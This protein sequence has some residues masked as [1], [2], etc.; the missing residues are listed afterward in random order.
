MLELHH[1]TLNAM[2]LKSNVKLENL[3][4]IDMYLFF[5]KGIRGGQSV[6]F[7][8]HSKAN[9]KYLND[10]N[11]NEESKHII[12]LDANNLYG[13]A[14][15]HK[16]P[17]SGFKWLPV[18]QMTYD[19]IMSYVDNDIGYVLEV[20]L[21][22]PEHLHDKHNDYP[23]APER[24]KVGKD[25]KLCGTF[26]DKKNYVVHIKNLKFYLEQGLELT[27]INRV[28][29]FKQS[30]WLEDWINLNTTFRTNAT[31]EF[32]K[33]YFKLM[34]NAVFGK[35]MENVRDRVDIKCAFN[36]D[37]FLKYTTK[38]NFKR[39]CKFGDDVNYFMVMEMEKKTVELNKPIY[40]GFSILDFSKLHMYKFHYE[41]MKNKYQDKIK[42]LMTDTDSLVYEV[43]TDDI[44]EDMNAM[45]DYFDMSEYPKDSKYHNGKNKK[46]IG[47]FKDEVSN[48]YISEFIGIR[49]KTYS[50]IKNNDEI[51]KK[52][53][54][55]S[56][57]VVKKEITFDDYKLCIFENKQKI[58][59]IHS[60]RSKD[61]SNYS[62]VQS[63]IAL[64][65]SDD[66]RCWIDA[67]NSLAWGHRR[68]I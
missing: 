24:F 19:K 47:K 16:L 49:S 48:D 34:N 64:N 21:K 10:Y 5:E 30:N 8:K 65:N 59:Q 31:N 43:Q 32:E 33:D 22:Y 37:Y 6:I 27:K 13:E 4:D 68:I 45:S 18:E 60:I 25:E 14:M 46:V 17:I 40:A 2:L 35:T 15:S 54:G 44:Y 66:K 29:E 1:F 7:N 23:L 62:L 9:H 63:K 11:P 61:L 55:V 67:T 56:K 26:Y 52:L 41:V 53:K 57:P 12:Y 50:F 39:A 58:V 3:S 38:P 20:D 51:S 28:I 36:E 42:L